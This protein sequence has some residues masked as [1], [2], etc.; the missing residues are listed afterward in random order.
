MKASDV[1][2]RVRDVVNDSG[3]VYR[4]SDT[5]LFRWITDCQSMLLNNIPSLFT[6][7]TAF[8]LSAGYSQSV[9]SLTGAVAFVEVVGA[10]KADLDLLTRFRPDWVNDAQGPLENWGPG[11]NGPLSFSVYP[12]SPAAQAVRV[13]YVEQPNA[14]AALTDTLAAPDNY[15][16]A[17]VQY[18]VGMV[19]STDDEHVNSNRAAQAK[20]DFIAMIR[21]A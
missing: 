18:C 11:G 2:S 12:P 16:P 15:L 20:A 4:N 10:P 6:K 3:S 19:E 1:V 14:V 7:T 9:S 5:S 21:G 17:I 13:S 8:N